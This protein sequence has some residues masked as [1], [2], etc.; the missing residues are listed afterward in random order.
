MNFREMIKEKNKMKKYLI[1]NCL[2]AFIMVFTLLSCGELD[3]AGIIGFG[4]GIGGVVSGGDA[5][6]G[7]V[8]IDNMLPEV[9][10]TILASFSGNGSGTASW[11][12]LR[13]D[14]VI[15]DATGRSYDVV[16]DLGKTLKAQVSF[17]KR[18]GSITSAATA[19]VT[20]TG[21]SVLT[22]TVT[23]NNTSPAV[24]SSLTATYNPGNNSGSA[25]WQWLRGGEVIPGATTAN[26]TVVIADAGS[27][28]RARVTYS[29][30]R[31]NVMSAATAVVPLPALTG[32]VSIDGSAVVG[33]TLTANTGSL[34][35]FAGANTFQWRRGGTNIGTNSNSYVI[36]STDA[37]SAITV[38]VTRAN[39]SS[40]VTSAPT[41]TVIRPPLTGSVSITGT[42]TVGQTL[43]ANIGS[44]GGNGNISYQ[45]KRGE[46]NIGTNSSTYT[47]V[48]ADSGSAIT[49]T[50]TRADNSGSISSSPTAAIA[51]AAL[52]GTVTINN[53]TPAV[54]QTLTATYSSGNGSGTA[55]WTW[56]RGGT[57][58]SGTNS[59]TYTVVAGDLGSTLRARVSYSNQTGF[60]ESS[61]TA[62]VLAAP[63]PPLTGSVS[64]TGTTTV[65]QTLTAN[66]GSL[67]GSGAISYQWRRDGAD[68][69]G[70]N[71]STYNLVQAD[72]GSRITVTVTRADNSG[73]VTSSQTAV[74]ANAALTGSV[75]INN[76]T[77]VV[78]DVLT[79]TY[80]PGNGS[81]TPTWTW[82]RGSTP[83]GANS[84][85]YTVV[86]GD[87]GSQLRVRVSYSNQSSN[88]ESAQTAAVV[89][90]PL[91]GSVSITGTTTVGQTLTANT[92]SLEGSGAISYQWRRS[93][94]NI[95]T[96]SNTY[97]LVQADSGST[98]TV[99]VTRANNSGSISSSPTAVIANAAL[100]G[101]VTINNTTPA[102]AQTLTA[103]YSS[104]NGSGAAS[105][106]WYRGGTLIS[107]ANSNT[108]TV[109]AG[110]VGSQLRARV[111]Y[112]NQTSFIESAQ[113]AVVTA[114]VDGFTT[115][116]GTYRGNPEHGT[117]TINGNI[118]T[119]S[120]ENGAAY[121]SMGSAP[122]SFTG[123]YSTN[124]AITYVDGGNIRFGNG[125]PIIGRYAYIE[126]F[127]ERRGLLVYFH[128]P[129][130]G[131]FYSY[132]IDLGSAEATATVT[133]L[134]AAG[135][136]FDAGVSYTGFSTIHLHQWGGDKL[137]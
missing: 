67:G 91:T 53:T 100:T 52:T 23:I 131:V 86:A 114:A 80:T 123:V 18:T 8:I 29:G 71:S 27:T 113:T 34:T 104:G 116:N 75:S 108:Y 25:S 46:T 132:R 42:T 105:W 93:G 12:W 59:R 95:G 5:L 83:I 79:A 32:T 54:G 37:G 130:F 94:T 68:I 40:S 109:V 82:L 70:A 21:L 126:S 3:E 87:V 90:P 125:G 47:L 49:V 137:P 11:V 120:M 133:G 107:G 44:L 127:D 129:D 88:V 50:V 57:E 77:P 119:T 7:T 134:V 51:N 81:G 19:A 38:T 99:T 39:H 118:L 58:I 112:S 135:A 61:S 16:K 66:T 65:G 63:P 15:L 72:S 111:S 136:V 122:D 33:Q 69:T 35:G 6:T 62:A 20:N 64:I 55:T 1:I 89:L 76:T 85:T 97:T 26:Y 41:T 106:T 22:G 73:S 45:W 117:V 48:Q 24:G 28:L 110:D 31:S 103:T 102:V 14:T 121:F 30:N 36:Q 78:G 101:T 2:I 115:W 13:D 17:E 124:Y 74:I 56:Y 60:I 10:E 4:S 9:G 92:G 98:I 84:N 128:A 43:T 96:N